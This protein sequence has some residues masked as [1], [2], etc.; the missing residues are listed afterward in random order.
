MAMLP[1]FEY[2]RVFLVKVSLKCLLKQIL[3]VLYLQFLNYIFKLCQDSGPGA[4]KQ[5]DSY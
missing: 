5:F 3:D 2:I 4:L 1:P